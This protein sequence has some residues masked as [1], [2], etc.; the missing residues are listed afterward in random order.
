MGWGVKRR[1]PVRAE[2]RKKE[3]RLEGGVPV[4]ACDCKK[5]NKD[6]EREGEP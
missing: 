4:W 2:K 3:V 1:T 6:G 5:K